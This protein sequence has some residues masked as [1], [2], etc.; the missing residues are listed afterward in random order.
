MKILIIFVFLCIQSQ[1]QELKVFQ[2]TPKS[3]K[4][5]KSIELIKKEKQ[6]ALAIEA[7]LKEQEKIKQEKERE[8]QAK[9]E[10]NFAKKSEIQEVAKKET[11][12]KVDEKGADFF[13]TLKDN[14]AKPVSIE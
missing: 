6:E 1:A 7:K 13:N 8:K 3:Q 12:V 2:D 4:V 14:S 5:L 10:K 11:N 9:I